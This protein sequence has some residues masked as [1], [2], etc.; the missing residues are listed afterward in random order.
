MYIY[1]Y[2]VVLALHSTFEQSIFLLQYQD[3]YDFICNHVV[4]VPDLNH[5]QVVHYYPVLLV[6][7]I[8]YI[9]IYMYIRH[10]IMRQFV[11]YH[12]IINKMRIEIKCIKARR[13]LAPEKIAA[14]RNRSFSFRR[15]RENY[16]YYEL[17]RFILETE[18]SPFP[19]I[20]KMVTQV[21]SCKTWAKRII[22]YLFISIIRLLLLLQFK[23]ARISANARKS[24]K[25]KGTFDLAVLYKERSS[26]SSSF[27]LYLSA[28]LAILNIKIPINGPCNL[29]SF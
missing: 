5:L 28:L 12:M 14:K 10:Y 25:E 21:M 6:V 23:V 7:L 20:K 24:I 29:E 9:I 1:I 17:F 16:Q 11:F 4:Y 18:R 22:T 2:N 19:L 26:L 3:L 8:Y 15:D 13:L 27:L